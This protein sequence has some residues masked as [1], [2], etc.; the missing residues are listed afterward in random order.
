MQV[1]NQ[2]NCGSCWAFSAAGALE[3]QYYRR[4]T[5]LISL[6]AQQL[7]D[8]SWNKGNAGCNGGLMDQAFEY[9][10][11]NDYICSAKS[12]PYLGYVSKREREEAKYETVPWKGYMAFIRGEW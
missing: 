9:V 5:T 11:D 3:G 8:C 2:G 6:S 10:R 1:K 4:T 12:Y 7:V